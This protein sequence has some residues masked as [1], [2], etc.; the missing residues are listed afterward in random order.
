MPTLPTFDDLY[1]AA[2]AEIQLRRPDLTDFNEG[3]NLDAIAGAAAVLADEVSRVAVALFAAQFFD[4][5]E[6]AELDALVQDRFGGSLVRKP[7]TAALGT[8]TWERDAAGAYVIPAGTRFRAT[9]GTTTITVQ[10]T[11]AVSLLS[12]ETETEIPVQAT[13]TG[14]AGNAA[15]GEID[16]IID[17]HVSDPGATCT[18]A[19]PL[20]GGS[21]AE[22]DEALRDRVRRVYST[23]RRGTKAALETGALS[24]PGVGIVTVDESEVESSGWVYVYVG[25]PDARGNDTLATLVETELEN[26]RCAG[27]LVEVQA[28]ERQEKSITMEVVVERGSDQVAV[29]AAIRAAVVAYGDSLGPGV[30]ARGSR[31][32]QAAHQASDLVVAVNDVSFGGGA[33]PSANYRAI[34]FTAETIAIAFTEAS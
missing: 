18:N 26:W 19:Q 10:S 25:D 31:V 15:A 23:L 29:A 2:R 33:S 3:S 21:D 30:R 4:T 6:G 8:V 17:V 34:R 5:A 27:V 7:A 11:V 1:N 14:R 32:E 24:V 12:T 16:E 22:T 9:F 20:A 28:A 13:V